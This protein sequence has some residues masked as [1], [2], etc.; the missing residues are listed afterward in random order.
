MHYVYILQ[1]IKNDSYYVGATSDLKKRIQ[2]HNS[3]STRYSSAQK[4]F[5]LA[6]YCSFVDKTKA[7]KFEK[8]LKH[9][10][11]HAFARKH[12]L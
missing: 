1:S 5:K 8:Y 6:W 10:S 11:G 9:G 12:L 4:P 7:L 3:G 2:E